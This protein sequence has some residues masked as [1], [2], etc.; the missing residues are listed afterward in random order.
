[1]RFADAY[2]GRNI[3]VTGAGGYIG[4][5][6][7]KDLAGFSPRSLALLDSSEQNL[8]NLRMPNSILGSVEDQALLDE[9]FRRFRPEIVFHAAAHKHVELLER[10]PFAAARNNVLGTNT[11]AQE[12]IRHGCGALVFVSTDKAVR[13]RSIMG[14]TK[15][16]AELL[17]TSLSQPRCRMNAVRLCNVMGSTGSVVPIFKEQIARGLPLTVTD[18]SAS[19]YFMPVEKAVEALLEAGASDR[20]GSIF[21]PDCGPPVSILQLAKTLMGDKVLPIEFIGLRAGEKISED[22]GSPLDSRKLSHDECRRVVERISQAVAARNMDELLEAIASVVAD[23][24]H[25]LVFGR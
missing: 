12:A 23:Y 9:I 15:R 3:L 25:S 5:A 18:K 20:S 4:S 24:E 14:A 16:V 17:I 11:L 13:P 10:N 6:L 21:L 19:R 2:S 8:F 1:M 22:L 7:V